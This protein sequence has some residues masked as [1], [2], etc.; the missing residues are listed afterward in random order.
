MATAARQPRTTAEHDE[1]RAQPTRKTKMAA[2]KA[3]MRAGPRAASWPCA[4]P[5]G[6]HAQPARRR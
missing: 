6:P 3:I 2:P 5:S 1:D 4:V